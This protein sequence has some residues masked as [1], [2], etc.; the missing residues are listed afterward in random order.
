MH[1]DSTFNDKRNIFSPQLYDFY[2]PLQNFSRKN[3]VPGKS[4][5]FIN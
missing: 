5:V 1:K 2:L 3:V 4:N